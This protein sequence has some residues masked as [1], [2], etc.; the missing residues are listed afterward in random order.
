MPVASATLP[1]KIAPER[2]TRSVHGGSEIA[3]GFAV[4]TANRHLRSKVRS[5]ENMLAAPMRSEDPV[6]SSIFENPG[7]DFHASE[8]SVA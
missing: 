5:I 4:S 6:R 2:S 1:S 7:I 8:I 3:A